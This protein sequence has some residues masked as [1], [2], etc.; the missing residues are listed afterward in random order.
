MRSWAADDRLATE[1]TW[2]VVVAD[3]VDE[4]ELSVE[5][6]APAAAPSFFWFFIEN[7]FII[8]EKSLNSNYIKNKNNLKYLNFLNPIFLFKI[9]F[10]IDAVLLKSLFQLRKI[11]RFKALYTKYILIFLNYLA[12]L[13]Q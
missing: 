9:R 6:W 8:L 2:F 3:G 12:Y 13:L 1:W 11:K 10:I 7:N 5:F 4:G